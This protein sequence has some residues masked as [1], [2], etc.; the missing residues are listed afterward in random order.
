MKQEIKE[1]LRENK[2]TTEEALATHIVELKRNTVIPRITYHLIDVLVNEKDSLLSFFA[3]S[4]LKEECKRVGAFPIDLWVSSVDLN[5]I[6]Y[7]L[8]YWGGKKEE[9]LKDDVITSS[10]KG[11]KETAEFLKESYKEIEGDKKTIY[12]GGLTEAE[13]KYFEVMSDYKL[14][15]ELEKYL[16]KYPFYN[17]TDKFTTKENLGR[18]GKTITYSKEDI[19]IKETEAYKETEGKLYYELDWSFV[20]QMAERMASNKKEGKYKLFNWKQPM[21][22]KGIED[23]KQATM[24]HLLEV[25]EGRYEDDGRKFGHLEAI[26][27]NMMMINYQLKLNKS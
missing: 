23:L 14:K 10:S 8:T 13:K 5:R 19:G 20:T 9:D 16:P 12:S 3:E 22:P 2:I 6:E 11:E 24:R 18:R 1:Y 25:M 27:D 15:E 21:T 7:P 26:S 17:I 4:N